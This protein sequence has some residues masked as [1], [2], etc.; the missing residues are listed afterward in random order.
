MGAS[1]QLNLARKYRPQHLKDVVG[2]DL[3]VKNLF[4]ALKS[5]RIAPAY[6]FS[7]PRG[8]GKTT[9]AR[10]FARG[11][12]CL[13]KE[14]SDRPCGKCNSCES[15]IKGQSMDLREIDGASHTGVDDVR[16]I[17]E[18][19]AYKPNISK[20]TV[21]IIDEVHMLSN[22]AFNALLKTLE[23]P[24]AHLLFLFATTEL[25]KIPA[26]ILS[27]T[28]RLELKRLSL[29][30]IIKNLETISAAEKL[31]VSKDTLQRIATAADG[32]LRDAQT[33]LDQMILLSGS[34]EISEE[35]VEKFLGTIG[36]SSEIEIL[37]LIAS[38]NSADLLNKLS[39]FF[40]NGKDLE[41]ILDRLVHWARAL[42]IDKSAPKSSVLQQEFDS[43]DLD[44]ARKAFQAWSVAEIDYLF[45][46]LWAGHERI[47]KSEMPRIILETSLLRAIRISSAAESPSVAAAP[48]QAPTQTP[49]QNSARHE[50][51]ADFQPSATYNRTSATSQSRAAPT[52]FSRPTATAAP[53]KVSP[54]RAPVAINSANE[55]L[56][57]IKIKRPNVSAL[58]Q[59]A[60]KSEL[61]G[62]LVV[63]TFSPN[64]F[65]VR[66]L[67]EKILKT[68]IE[69]LIREISGGKFTAYELIESGAK[70][71]S[72]KPASSVGG[73]NFMAD[74][75]K[76]IVNDP[77]VQRAA[78]LLGAEV[79]SVTIEGIKNP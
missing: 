2:Q 51:P 73:R 44:R 55:L 19:V 65:A 42:L 54:P 21:Y 41:A 15:Y 18:S 30:L 13:S 32:S 28:Q 67:S 16:S 26:T 14:F 69:A 17:I 71:S 10:I 57:E 1:L 78:E 33:L 75:K 46:V 25:E 62:N 58:L 37:E 34:S 53:Q 4:E 29:P 59:C 74:A 70:T 79:E 23:E 72:E 35:V 50:R 64:H 11:A 24:P 3:V 38:R 47:K 31:K 68:E 5:D 20:R 43:A 66:Q 48:T 77:S 8:T 52:S 60:E 6:L 45:E 36:I 12:A 40:Q 7:G 27:R 22:A 56:R 63:L 39:L 61:R 9:C 76:V 49:T